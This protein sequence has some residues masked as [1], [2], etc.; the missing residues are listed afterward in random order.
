M[1]ITIVSVFVVATLLLAVLY[2]LCLIS[3]KI[4]RKWWFGTLIRRINGI[5]TISCGNTITY[6]NTSTLMNVSANEARDIEVRFVKKLRSNLFMALLGFV[7][8]SLT[9]VK[10]ALG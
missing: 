2:V 10:K 5:K 6:M 3:L 1:V 4:E 8:I 7:L 9:V